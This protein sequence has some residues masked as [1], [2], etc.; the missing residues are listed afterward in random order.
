[1]TTIKKLTLLGCSLSVLLLTAC[2]AGH[3]KPE[4][5]DT[6]GAYDGVWVAEVGGPRA[7][8]VILPGNWRMSCDWEP[9][10]VYIVIDDGRVQ[11]GKIEGKSAISKGGQFRYDLA[12]GDAGMRGGIMSGNSK[13]MQIFSGNLSGDD[14]K[15]VYRQYVASL[16]GE[17]CTSTIHFRRYDSSE[18]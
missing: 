5:R 9:Y 13:F 15:G 11:L 4:D 18:A 17:G 10:E 3:V 2:A 8:T 1:M 7:T 6:T 14:P 16:H 12:S